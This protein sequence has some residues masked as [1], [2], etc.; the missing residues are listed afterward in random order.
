MLTWQAPIFGDASQLLP[1]V[2][3]LSVEEGLPIVRLQGGAKKSD[4]RGS[5]KETGKL[6]HTRVRMRRS[7]RISSAKRRYFLF[8]GAL[9]R[10]ATRRRSS[11]VEVALSNRR[12]GIRWAAHGALGKAPC[13]D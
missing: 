5:E 4:D 6:I 11:T 13:F 3:R 8:E 1:A 9:S 12:L 7:G 10:F 2:E